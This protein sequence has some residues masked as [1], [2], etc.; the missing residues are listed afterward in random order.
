MFHER[1]ERALAALGSQSIAVLPAAPVYIRNNDVEHEYRP[2]SDLYYLTGFDEPE[3]VLVLV[4]GHAEHRT[5]LFVRSRDPD[6]EVWD[7]P[8]AG[9]EGAVARYGADAAFPI[10]ELDERLTDYLAGRGRLY[11]ALGVHRGFDDR[12]LAAIARARARARKGGRWPT[13]IVEPGTILHEMRLIKSADELAIM[14]TAAE[15]TRDA[16]ARAM[17]VARPG[18]HEYEVE[19]MLRAAFR[20]RGAERAAYEPIVASGP[21]ACVLHYRANNRR[22]DDG[23]LLLVDAGAEFG[24]YASDVTRTFPVN[25]RFSPAQRRVYQI[26]LDAQLAAIEAV[27]PGATLPAVHRRAVEVITAGLCA[28]GV[29]AGE[30]DQLIKDEAYKKYYMHGTSH[31]LGMDVHDVGVYYLDADPRPLAPG[32]VVT[33]EPG[34]YFAPGD[35]QLPAELRGIGV[36]IE[37]DVACT[38]DGRR[39]LTHD[40]PK[41]PDE[42][43]ALLGARGGRSEPAAAGG[44]AHV[45]S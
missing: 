7:G 21:N 5:V 24:C 16:F 19:G 26:V 45:V 34:L 31:W 10:G 29:L 37:D 32:H 38:V 41:Q 1:R 14:R 11:Y 39:V 9:V 13:E 18:R 8:R 40:I 17:D 22:M 30:L 15:I 33:V 4:P 20:A 25:G 12:V 42:L 27:G 43:E 3:S 2:D 35:T 28:L 36:R 23:D 6:R 44:R